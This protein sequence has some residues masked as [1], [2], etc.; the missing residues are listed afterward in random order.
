MESLNSRLSRY[1]TAL[2]KATSPA[3]TLRF[4]VQ[5][6]DAE[7][8]SIAADI[9]RGVPPE[10]YVLLLERQRR[11]D[12]D[13]TI[14]RGFIEVIEGRQLPGADLPPVRLPSTTYPSQ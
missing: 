7:D 4:C 14:L 12:D 13:R 10:Q 11:L 9:R 3:D 1:A 5:V 2:P 6:F 8:A